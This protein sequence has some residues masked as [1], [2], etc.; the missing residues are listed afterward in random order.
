M[1]TSRQPCDAVGVRAIAETRR[2]ITRAVE[3]ARGLVGRRQ[4]VRQLGSVV[5]AA[6][7][8]GV[9]RVL[10]GRALG[11][12]RSVYVEIAPVSPELEDL[13]TELG[14]AIGAAAWSL[15]SRRSGP[16]QVVEL[17]GVRTS[18]AA[19]GRVM[20]A[21][22]F[23]VREGSQSRPVVLHY[24]PDQRA[25]ATRALVQHLAPRPA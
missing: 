7:L 14:R 22:S 20:E 17:L 2:F 1:S 18:R 15:A 24:P 19:D 11:A 13:V 9:P 4:D 3:A 23:A 8:L 21:A 12:R 5:L 25:R 16:T 6:V 10:E